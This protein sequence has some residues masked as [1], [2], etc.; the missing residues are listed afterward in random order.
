M[1]HR[2]RAEPFLEDG[3][4]LREGVVKF[5]FIFAEVGVVVNVLTKH[6]R[7]HLRVEGGVQN[8]GVPHL[9]Q[10]LAGNQ[11][12]VRVFQHENQV[13]TVPED[14]E[15]SLLFRPFV[16]VFFQRLHERLFEWT[17]IQPL[18]DFNAATNSARPT[19]SKAPIRAMVKGTR[20]VTGSE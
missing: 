1:S 19:H 12:R 10:E 7:T 9:V 13:T 17:E 16:A 15:V 3:Q 8:V 18:K 11:R 5:D 6:F 2:S 20:D 4:G 14:T